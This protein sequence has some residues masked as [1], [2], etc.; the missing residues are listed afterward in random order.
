[1]D[2]FDKHSSPQ[3]P[4]P[5]SFDFGEWIQ[6]LRKSRRF[7]RQT[8]SERASEKGFS[9][10]QQYVHF[11]ETGKA[12]NIGSDKVQALAIGLNVPLQI[13]EQA[14]FQK[15]APIFR[16]LGRV[17]AGQA[18][19]SNSDEY[20]EPLPYV[21]YGKETQ[22]LYYVEISG[23]SMAPKIEH[24]DL[25]LVKPF[26]KAWHDQANY[27]NYHGLISSGR[28]YLIQ[29]PK[30]QHHTCKYILADNEQEGEYWLLAENEALFPKTRLDNRFKVL[31]EVIEV[32]KTLS[33]SRPTL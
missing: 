11:I 15:K 24:G 16:L 33:L 6:Q 21:E 29:E 19:S 14:L 23:D 10:S 2:R 22:D 7:S 26:P 1:M 13:I 9:L 25:A 17:S 31:G 20:G 5:I 18:T 30:R 32:R 4:K 8:V 12:T 28:V 3:Q 27:P